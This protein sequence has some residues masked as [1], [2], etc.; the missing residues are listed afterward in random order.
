MFILHTQNPFTSMY[1]IF[2]SDRFSQFSAVAY[3][4][5]H[6]RGVYR[7]ARY[8]QNRVPVDYLQGFLDPM[9]SVRVVVRTIIFGVL[10][11][12]CLEELTR[13]N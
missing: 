5:S 6:V 9:F 3:A 2:S 1:I 8:N 11:L 12:L 10:S 7:E 4:L 13:F